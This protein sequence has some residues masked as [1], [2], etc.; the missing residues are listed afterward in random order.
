MRTKRIIIKNNITELDRINEKIKILTREWSLP[1]S[2]VFNVNLV[3][4]EIFSNIVFYGYA[5]NEEHYIFI[6]FTSEPGFLKIKI[7]DDA[8]EFNPLIFP[9]NNSCGCLNPIDAE[10]GGLG[11]H[12]VKNL[13]DELYYSRTNDKNILVMSKAFNGRNNGNY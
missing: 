5:D 6:S 3:I 9:T 2:L 4:E 1:S 13:M 7:E 10:I 12:L 8:Q 11:I